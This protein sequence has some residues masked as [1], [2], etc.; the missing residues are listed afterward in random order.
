MNNLNALSLRVAENTCATATCQNTTTPF[1]KWEILHVLPILQINKKISCSPFEL[2][3][4]FCLSN[5][6]KKIS[7]MAP[8]Q[9]TETTYNKY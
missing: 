5:M 7:K 9:L 6:F 4:L 8:L 1:P 2:N 3:A